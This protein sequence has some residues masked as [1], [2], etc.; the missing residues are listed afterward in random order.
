MVEN[1][2]LSKRLGAPNLFTR[3]Q[4]HLP[5]SPLPRNNSFDTD[6]NYINGKMAPAKVI[7]Q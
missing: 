7:E 6:G 2:P 3:V 1:I 4:L 5:T